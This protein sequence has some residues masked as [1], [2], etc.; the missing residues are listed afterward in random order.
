MFQQPFLCSSTPS[1][2]H[3]ERCWHCTASFCSYSVSVYEWIPSS[4]LAPGSIIINAGVNQPPGVQIKAQPV[5]TGSFPMHFLS[6]RF[7]SIVLKSGAE[8]AAVWAGSYCSPINCSI[9][10]YILNCSPEESFCEK[11]T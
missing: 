6:F 3:A 7:R 2:L 8:E 5:Y 11:V 10:L 4:I 9:G 1:I